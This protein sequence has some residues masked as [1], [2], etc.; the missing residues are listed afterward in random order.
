MHFVL[1]SSLETEGGRNRGNQLQGL[2]FV[3]RIQIFGGAA[4][5]ENRYLFCAFLAPRDFFVVS[6]H[7]FLL[8]VKAST[9]ASRLFRGGC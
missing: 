4:E 5:N 7:N 6:D 2:Q 3:F 8:G 9:F 1:V